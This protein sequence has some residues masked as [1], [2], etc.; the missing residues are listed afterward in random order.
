LLGE[1]GEGALEGADVR[2]LGVTGVQLDVGQARVVV[3]HAVQVVVARATR[4]PVARGAS[5]GAV[6][7]GF[8]AGE[9]LD[10]HVQQRAGPRPLV[11]AIALALAARAPR[12]TV[13]VEDLPSFAGRPRYSARRVLRFVGHNAG[14]LDVA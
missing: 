9:A 4:A 10:V 5:F 8:E 14:L 7:G 11:A 3:D 12:E 6:A 2:L 1:E 13:A